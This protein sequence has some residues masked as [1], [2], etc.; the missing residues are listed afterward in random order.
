[1]DTTEVTMLTPAA[2]KNAARTE[3]EAATENE[4]ERQHER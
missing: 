4:G 1:M 3:M 2:A